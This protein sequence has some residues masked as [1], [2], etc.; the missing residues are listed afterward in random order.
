M[1]NKIIRI[2]LILVVAC[3]IGL[4]AYNKINRDDALASERKATMRGSRDI[5]ADAYIVR[6]TSL[7]ND[8]NATGTL[9][10]NESIVV[11]PQ[12]NGRIT[13]LYFKEGAYVKKGDL[14]VALYDGDLTAQLDKTKIQQRLADTMLSRQ[15]QLLR[16]NGISRQN[17]DNTSNQ[18]AAYEADI[19]YYKAEISKTRIVAPFNGRVG[20]RQVSE[21]AIVS[22][23]TVITTLYQNDP[24]KLEFSIPEKYRNQ[25][26][27]G[28][29]VSFKVSEMPDEQFTGKVYALNPG[30]DPQTR[31]VTLRALVSNKAGKLASGSF[32]NVHINLR[33]IAGALMIPTQSLIS[34]TQNSQVIL[35]RNGK[36]AFVTVETGIRTPDKVQ[37]LSGL[38]PGD[39]VLTTGIMQAGPGDPLKIMQIDSE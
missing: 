16:I 38:K 32:A 11:Q 36:A 5:M 12:I 8:I 28:D 4:L 7:K 18:V 22:P 39:T 37:I 1:S 33:E 24:L 20:L 27:R 9:L 26:K 25:L 35:N 15:K 30:I 13:H 21:G 2:I 3:G 6:A 29:Q 17:V 19:D 31:T 14:L 10:S 34:T 23:T